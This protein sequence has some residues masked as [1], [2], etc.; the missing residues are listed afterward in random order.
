MRANILLGISSEA[1]QHAIMPKS[2]PMI[3]NDVKRT[4]PIRA[5]VSKLNKFEKK[6]EDD[7]LRDFRAV[8][9]SFPIGFLESLSLQYPACKRPSVFVHANIFK[10][11]N[12]IELGKLS[13]NDLAICVKLFITVTPDPSENMSATNSK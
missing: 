10:S 12:G 11:V 9:D 5:L 3:K 2:A 6:F 4:R 7:E 13:P 8:L 1:N